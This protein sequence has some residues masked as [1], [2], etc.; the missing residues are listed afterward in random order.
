V[1]V[2]HSSGRIQHGQQ[3]HSMGFFMVRPTSLRCGHDGVCGKRVRRIATCVFRVSASRLT[4]RLSLPAAL[5]TL[6]LLLI[7]KGVNM[8]RINL[9]PLMNLSDGFQLS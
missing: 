5:Y 6:E 1:T 4:E 2:W 7:E 9:D 8:S 3:P